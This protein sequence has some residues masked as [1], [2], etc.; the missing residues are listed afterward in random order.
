MRN[1]IWIIVVSFLILFISC[2]KKNSKIDTES[3]PVNSGMT[4]TKIYNDIE[5]RHKL[6]ELVYTKGDTLA[7]RELYDIYFI[8]GNKN[9]FLN[10]A[11]VMANN[12]N[13]SDGSYV[14]YSLLST[15]KN[16]GSKSNKL[17]NY[18]LLKACEMDKESGYD[19][20]LEE[21]FGDK[22]IPKSEDYWL[23]INK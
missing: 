17:A 13:S 21:R 9:D 16:L 8:S 20:D 12:Y 10:I 1:L 2:D 18:Y 19:A 14:T 6:E 11:M 4:Y 23:E 5:K 3:E 15:D 7:Y 22:T